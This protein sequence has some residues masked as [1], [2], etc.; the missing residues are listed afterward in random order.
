MRREANERERAYNLSKC[1]VCAKCKSKN[2]DSTSKLNYRVAHKTLIETKLRGDTT[3]MSTTCMD[4]GTVSPIR[5]ESYTSL[6]S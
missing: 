3:N 1:N 5:L 4:A 2:S 6:N